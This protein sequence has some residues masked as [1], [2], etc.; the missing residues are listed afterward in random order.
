MSPERCP[1]ATENFNFPL[2]IIDN[3]ANIFPCDGGSPPDKGFYIS[4]SLLPFRRR[5]TTLWRRERRRRQCELNV[6]AKSRRK[7]D[8]TE[9]QKRDGEN[10]YIREIRWM[11]FIAKEKET[12]TQRVRQRE[13]KWNKMLMAK[14]NAGN[15]R[16]ERTSLRRAS[17]SALSYKYV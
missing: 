14:G 6:T 5:S 2:E 3:N 17:S 1:A 16:T 12:Y 8:E 11:S 7:R 15:E 4:T 13:W 10:V 9:T